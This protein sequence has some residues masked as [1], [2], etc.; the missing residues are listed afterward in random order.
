MKNIKAI[1][2][3]NTNKLLSSFEDG[4]EIPV[5]TTLSEGDVLTITFPD[6]P[7]LKELKFG[8]GK[9]SDIKLIIVRPNEDGTGSIEGVYKTLNTEQVCCDCGGWIACGSVGCSC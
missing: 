8:L 9:G 5:T 4:S 7:A 6:V 1:I 2:L 3:N